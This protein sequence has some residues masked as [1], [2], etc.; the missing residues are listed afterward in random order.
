M[1]SR[2]FSPS[3]ASCSCLLSLLIR[4]SG[5]FAALART[6]ASISAKR[7]PGMSSRVDQYLLVRQGIFSASRVIISRFRRMSGRALRRAAT[8]FGRSRKPVPSGLTGHWASLKQVQNLL[9]LIFAAKDR[10]CFLE[11]RQGL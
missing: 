4:G 2:T 8:V 11:F 3:R 10:S 5:F 1:H 6:R 9:H 7:R